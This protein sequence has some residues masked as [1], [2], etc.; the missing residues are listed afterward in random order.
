MREF[1]RANM[2]HRV[3]IIGQVAGTPEQVAPSK[4]RFYL[5][6]TTGGDEKHRTIWFTIFA[7]GRLAL[8]HR[9]L[10]KGERLLI[11]GVLTA[12]QAGHPYV[13][14]NSEGKSFARYEIRALAISLMGASSSNSEISDLVEGID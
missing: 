2:Y 14:A 4:I 6:S 1:E 13:R 9:N 3:I 11:E 10:Q 12:D 7:N 8:T 5:A